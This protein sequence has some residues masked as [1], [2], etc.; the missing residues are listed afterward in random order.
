MAYRIKTQ[1]TFCVYE[2]SGKLIVVSEN[3]GSSLTRDY[4]RIKLGLTA[5][6]AFDFV[7]DRR[8]NTKF[9]VVAYPSGVVEVVTS[10]PKYSENREVYV[11]GRSL[12]YVDRFLKARNK[13]ASLKERF[14][15]E[16]NLKRS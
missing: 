8:A 5:S 1:K 4:I 3:L 15:T 14:L 11:F 2:G 6:E 12:P 16:S 7:E 10:I 9:V 13:A